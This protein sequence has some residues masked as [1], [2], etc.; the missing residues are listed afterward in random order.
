MKRGDEIIFLLRTQSFTKKAIF[1]YFLPPYCPLSVCDTYDTETLR[2]H[3]TK[4]QSNHINILEVE[5]DLTPFYVT[6]IKLKVA[7]SNHNLILQNLKH[8]WKV[9][10]MQLKLVETHAIEM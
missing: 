5:D 1:Q 9:T 10:K 4:V 6:A 7:F 3:C 8:K 2:K